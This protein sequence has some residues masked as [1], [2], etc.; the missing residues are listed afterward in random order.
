MLLMDIA[1]A[2]LIGQSGS[3]PGTTATRKDFY[4]WAFRE[5]FGTIKP[6]TGEL[7]QMPLAA[8]AGPDDLRAG[9]PYELP[10]ESLPSDVGGQVQYVRMRVAEST[11]L[12]TLI[13]EKLDPTPKQKDLLKLMANID[14]AMAAK[15]P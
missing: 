14:V 8:G 2:V 12:R 6:I 7:R 3:A 15:I 4:G 13:L 5:M 11:Q 10:N 9:I 1:L